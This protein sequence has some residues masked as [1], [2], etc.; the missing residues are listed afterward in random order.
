MDNLKDAIKISSGKYREIYAI[1]NYVIKLLKKPSNILETAKSAFLKAYFMGVSKGIKDLNE[2]EYLNYLS[3]KKKINHNI[4]PFSEEQKYF[5]HIYGVFNVNKKSYSLG[6]L[7]R[8][9]NQ[10]ISKSLYSSNL[11]PSFLK[12]FERFKEI[13]MDLKIYLYDL[14][15]Y[16]I[17]VRNNQAQYP[18]LVNYKRSPETYPLQL[19]NSENKLMVKL[20]RRFKRLT[21]YIKQKI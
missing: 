8:D 4:G 17:L 12:E 21:E 1:D 11:K 20:E 5:A 10:E 6:E 7:I 9:N 2:L 16:N 13:I 15:E 19:L 18:V 14:N 3:L